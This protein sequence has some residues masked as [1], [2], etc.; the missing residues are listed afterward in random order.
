MRK[1]KRR[2]ENVEIGDNKIQAVIFV[3]HT[4][5]SK[6]GKRMR[7]KLD[8]LEKLGSIKINLKKELEIS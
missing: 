1:R 6:M 8:S 7:E 3:Q 2:K 5:F 4:E